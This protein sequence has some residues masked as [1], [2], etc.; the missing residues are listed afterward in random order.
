MKVVFFCHSRRYVVLIEVII[1]MTLT[2]ALLTLLMG[3]YSQVERTN[4]AAEK[5][6]NKSFQKLYLS[7][8]LAEILPK[9]LAASDSKK[10]FIFYTPANWDGVSLSN[11]PSLLFSFDNGVRLASEFSD[12]VI[13]KLYVDKDGAFSLGMW[14]SFLRWNDVTSPPMKNEVL[15]ENVEQLQIEFYVPPQRDR[16]I[17]WE[18]NKAGIK[19]SEDLQLDNLGG[20]R[21]EWLQEYKEL[22]VLIRLTLKV[23]TAEGPEEI[24]LVYPLPNSHLFIM[25]ER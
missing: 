3:F 15:M 2:I 24:V 6:Q 8:R 16:K 25:Y 20:W 21:T 9:T 7:T 19:A 1:A 12:H 18:K 17:I 14:P 5:V 22:P 10:D 13:G 4:L 11:A 23:K